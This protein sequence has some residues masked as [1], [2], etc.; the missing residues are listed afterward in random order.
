MRTVFLP[1]LLLFLA[2]LTFGQTTPDKKNLN[3]DG[4]GIALE[5]YDPVAYFKQHKAIK[6]KAGIALDNEGV[7]Y[8]F[9]TE[10]NKIAFLKAPSSYK[11]QYGGWCAYAM[12]AKGEK[13][14]VDPETFKLIDGKLYL[15]YNRLFN[16][17]LETWNKNEVELKANADKNW[18]QLIKR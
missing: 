16:N 7:R 8:L 18:S 11:P 10:E 12:G 17:T 9:S 15:F 1:T 6:G 14:E 5:G 13:V 2:V 3:L 4:S